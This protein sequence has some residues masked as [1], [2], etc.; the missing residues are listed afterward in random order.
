MIVKGIRKRLLLRILYGFSFVC[1][2]ISMVLFSLIPLNDTGKSPLYYPEKT[3][4]PVAAKATP[5]I[6]MFAAENFMNSGKGNDLW[7]KNYATLILENKRDHDVKVDLAFLAKSWGNVSRLSIKKNNG[8]LERYSLS[9]DG[10][11]IKVGN[12]L[13]AP[14]ENQLLLSSLDGRIQPPIGE[15]LKKGDRVSM[16]LGSFTVSEEAKDG[17]SDV[18]MRHIK[19]QQLLSKIDRLNFVLLFIISALILLVTFT[20]DTFNKFNSE[21]T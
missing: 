4:I 5:G 2:Y 21:W 15:G 1:I 16:R 18:E 6:K 9:P 7:V 8:T 3:A 11:H 10:G 12:I 14:G 13:L 19:R 20:I 17:Y